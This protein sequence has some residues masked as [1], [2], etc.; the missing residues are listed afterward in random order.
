MLGAVVALR[1]HRYHVVP[2]LQGVEAYARLE[3]PLQP[4]VEGLDDVRRVD[5]PPHRRR[6]S[7]E[8]EKLGH[9]EV[10]P[11]RRIGLAPFADEGGEAGF[12][13]FLGARRVDAGE[14]VEY[15]LPVLPSGAGGHVSADVDEASLLLGAREDLRYRLRHPLEAV[16][17]EEKGIA[18]AARLH[19]PQAIGPFG[20]GFAGHYPEPQ[21][22]L[23][24]LAGDAE[25]DH[26][27]FLL[28]AVAA[29][30][31]SPDGEPRPVQIDDRAARE[32]PGIE[33]LGLPVA[34]LDD[35]EDEPLRNAGPGPGL[36][37]LRDVGAGHPLGVQPADLRV[38]IVDA[39]PVFAQYPLLEQVEA[40]PRDP[41]VQGAD[42][43]EDGPL[44]IAV[45]RR[46]LP[47]E[48][49]LEEGLERVL[50]GLIDG[51]FGRLPEEFR[52]KGYTLRVFLVK[53]VHVAFSFF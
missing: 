41:D 9:V 3:L 11:E 23:P 8:R 45:P 5:G 51:L 40:V 39:A 20:R 2:V 38:E 32:R 29:F 43:R 25:G 44:V 10:F 17:D 31:A 37:E 30:V 50:H 53:I 36:D 48:A 7:V 14:A 26:H 21:D 19:A 1:L 18:Q 52:R 22:L 35:R 49:V 4:P 15:L 13:L 33:F 34:S 27:A 12:G 6:E 24:A 16:G 47:A 42:G 28:V 46:G